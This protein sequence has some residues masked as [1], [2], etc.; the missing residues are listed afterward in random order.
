MNDLH[1]HLQNQ[2]KSSKYAGFLVIFCVFFNFCLILA[3]K[4]IMVVI[5]RSFR[6][7]WYP[8]HPWGRLSS[9]DIWVLRFVLNILLQRRHLVEIFI[10][11]KMISHVHFIILVHQTVILSLL[12]LTKLT[13]DKIHHLIRLRFEQSEL[14]KP[15][16]V[17]IIRYSTPRLND[18]CFHMIFLYI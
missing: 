4:R 17:R 5:L 10:Y 16:C 13:I 6:F 14:K 15:Q 2:Q 18:F 7:F 1:K 9:G 12:I 8:W 11:I 3:A